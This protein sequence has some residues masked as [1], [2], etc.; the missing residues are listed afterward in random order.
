[1][2]LW[3]FTPRFGHR[4]QLASVHWLRLDPRVLLLRGRQAVCA[5]LA[6]GVLPVLVV[7]KWSLNL[8]GGSCDHPGGG[9]C[10]V[11]VRGVS[12]PKR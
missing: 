10:H 12:S 2:N 8:A 7:R 9:S 3:A 1:M 5:Q 4:Y 6:A 11:S